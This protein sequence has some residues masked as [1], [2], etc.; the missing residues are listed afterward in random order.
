M[1][2]GTASQDLPVNV[3]GSWAV[4][5]QEQAGLNA[6]MAM[7]S[8]ARSCAFT[9]S[10]NSLSGTCTGREGSS[11]ATG[12]IDGRQVRWAWKHD[13]ARHVGEVDFIGMMGED[14]AITG[15]SIVDTGFYRLALFKAEPVAK[16]ASGK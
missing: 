6:L 9:Q 3:S 4:S 11:I 8:E 5:I 7:Q 16:I 2:L 15:Q 13:D 10:G 12:V 1:P 14:G